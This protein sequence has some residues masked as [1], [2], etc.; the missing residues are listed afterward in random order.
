MP[1]GFELLGPLLAGDRKARRAQ[2]QACNLT[3]SPCSDEYDS[4]AGDTH[5]WTR[6][7]R[8][9]SAAD[10]PH[11][12][13]VPR[14]PPDLPSIEL[15]VAT[16]A[17]KPLLHFSYACDNAAAHAPSRPRQQLVSLSAACVAFQGATRDAVHSVASPA[18]VFVSMHV[19]S[20]HIVASSSD[21][22]TPIHFLIALVRL[23]VASLNAVLSASFADVL[24]SRPNTDAGRILDEVDAFLQTV[25]LNAITYPVPYA[26]VSAATLPCPTAPRSRSRVT[27]ILRDI[28]AESPLTT[29]HALL[30]TASPP[31]P[32][33]LIAAASTANHQLTPLDILLLTCFAPHDTDKQ[34]PEVQRVFLQTYG[35]RRASYVSLRN[36]HLRLDPDDF[37]TFKSAVGG[38]SWR[39]EWG[40]AG[41][42]VVW[43]LVVSRGPRDVRDAANTFLDTVE[44]KLDRS[45]AVRDVMIAME[46][47]WTL[48]DLPETM[49][50]SDVAAVRAMLLFDKSRVAGALGSFTHHVGLAVIKAIFQPTEQRQAHSRDE[51]LY[52]THCTRSNLIVV[53]WRRSIVVCI[54]DSMS[55][56]RALAVC[57][58]QI[59]P[60]LQKCL[61]SLLP[62]HE[63]VTVPHPTPLAHL[64]SP[65]DS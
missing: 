62:Q 65:F 53:V 36:V 31:L 41:G 26:F 61:R 14:P 40:S 42:D 35:F 7:N 38:T 59:V 22:S 20:F 13:A 21:R 24:L 17:G 58:H 47:P 64:L 6:M 18:G 37:D 27:R 29:T 10:L 28:L 16:P 55:R 9:D 19:Q 2:M 50:L 56:Q 32:R 39:P 57:A 45:T 52:S 8:S 12:A 34:P 1:R 30:F 5:F 46:R 48:R 43:I 51:D 11:M 23:A 33:L 44:N 3:T 60:W 25:L 49:R 4:D 63:R 54:D 15:I